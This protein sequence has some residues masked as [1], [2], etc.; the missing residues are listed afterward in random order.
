[1]IAKIKNNQ[2]QIPDNKEKAI[3]T[4]DASRANTAIET[5]Q[6]ICRTDGENL[7]VTTQITYRRQLRASHLELLKKKNI[8]QE[9][10]N[11][12]HLLWF[13]TKVLFF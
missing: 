9:A 13:K 11:K 2:S 6:K 7:K 10:K 8:E 12:K 5:I 4:I 1:M 3:L